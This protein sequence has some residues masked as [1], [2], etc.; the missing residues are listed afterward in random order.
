[1]HRLS[2]REVAFDSAAS[3]NMEEARCCTVT[4]RGRQNADCSTASFEGGCVK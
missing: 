2:T 4:G 3:R 1:M